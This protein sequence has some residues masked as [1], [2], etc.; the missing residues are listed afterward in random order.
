[1]KNFESTCHMNSDSWQGQFHCE[2][3]INLLRRFLYFIR[4]TEVNAS[5]SKNLKVT[6]S[7]MYVFLAY[8]NPQ[9]HIACI[10]FYHF[11]PYTY[12]IHT[13][14]QFKFRRIF[15]VWHFK[16]IFHFST[17]LY[18]FIC[19]NVISTFPFCWCCWLEITASEISHIWTHTQNF[20]SSR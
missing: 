10:Q 11:N 12:I 6:K 8:P 3:K 14:T 2:P 1:M 9:S 7:S 19:Y 5:I 13:H 16:L 17:I 18:I 4:I 15:I 20:F